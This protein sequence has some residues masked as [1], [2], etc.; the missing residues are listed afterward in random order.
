MFFLIALNHPAH[1]HLF[2]NFRKEMIKKEHRVVF[3]LKEK[4][5]LSKLLDFEGVDYIKIIKKRYLRNRKFSI[6]S[7]NIIELIKNNMGL[8]RYVKSAKPDF[9]LG[10]DVSIAHISAI[11]RIPSFI[12]N[13][14]D[15]DVNKL[16]C[17]SSYPFTK[18]IVSPAICNVGKYEY[19]RIKYDG[20]QKLAYLHPNQF[21]PNTNVLSSRFSNS[22]KNII[23]RMVSFTAGHDIEQNHSGISESLLDKIIN[24]LKNHGQI[25]I[26]SEKKL[27]EKYSQFALDIKITDIHDY[28]SAA[29]IFISDSQSMTVEACM[30]GTPS[31]RF[32]SFAGKISVLNELENNYEL[33][34]S[35]N[36]HDEKR[37]LNKLD[38]LICS[39]NLKEVYQ[40][41]R[42][43]MLDDKIDLTAFLVWMFKNYSNNVSELIKHPE[44]QNQFK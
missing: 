34:Y 18:Y 3:I 12:F 39:T 36:I 10:T 29:D 21:T 37:F 20:Y 16:F 30:L 8:Y 13:E 1:Y 35:Y 15:I 7:S 32:N 23:I 9:L 41:R 44:I 25:H 17:Y 19:K 5:I 40:E 33:T 6:I 24:K 26:S 11:T 42:N 22:N 43:K 27:P 4:E 2:K 28:I 38:E 31:L 14:D